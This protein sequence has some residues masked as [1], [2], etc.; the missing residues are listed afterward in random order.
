MSNLLTKKQSDGLTPI[1]ALQNQ[2]GK[3]FD[4][5]FDGFEENFFS[6]HYHLAK[7]FQPKVNISETDKIYLVEANLAGIKKDE[8]RI[9][10]KDNTLSISAKK[11]EKKEEENKNYHRFEYSSGSFYRNFQLPSNIEQKDV[12]AEMKDGVLKI[13]LPKGDKHLSETKQIIIK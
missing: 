5:F 11:E 13:T 6:K 8:V 10:C 7:T 4:N 9:D 3:L 12:T 2:V 1:H